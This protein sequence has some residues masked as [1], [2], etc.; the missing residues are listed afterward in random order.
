MKKASFF[1]VLT[2]VLSACNFSSTIIVMPG[3]KTLPADGGTFTLEITT[4]YW[5]QVECDSDWISFSATTGQGNGTV[6]VYVDPNTHSDAT[7]DIIRVRDTDN[8]NMV[9]VIVTREGTGEKP[10]D[11]PDKPHQNPNAPIEVDMTEIEFSAYSSFQK[12]NI[13]TDPDM[14]WSATSNASWIT[15]TPGVGKGNQTISIISEE[16]PSDVHEPTKAIVTV[17]PYPSQGE[18]SKTYINITRAGW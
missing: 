6:E 13:T 5:W 2:L 4:E 17:Q 18:E 3:I 10:Q 9:Q 12:V 11:D 7:S 8:D 16:T 14:K 15:V 1:F